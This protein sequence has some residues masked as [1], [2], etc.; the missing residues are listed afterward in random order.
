M[1][2]E[3]PLR[4]IH[5][6]EAI[7]WWPPAIGWWLLLFVILA[8][9]VGGWMLYKKLTRRTAIKTGLEM[10]L[11]IKHSEENDQLALLKQLSSCIRRV[12]MSTDSRAEV[13]SLTGEK[14]LN[15]LDLSVEGTPFSSG[16]GK[17]LADAHYRQTPPDGLDSAALINLCES[18]I[19]GRKA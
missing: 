6:P 13:A 1:D 7:T 12:A 16:V 19:K 15:Y 4:D 8:A 5:L 3:L 14:W 17:C 9:L 18:W 10:L 11:S 2:Q